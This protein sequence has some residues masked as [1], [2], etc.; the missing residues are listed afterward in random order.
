MNSLEQLTSKSAATQTHEAT[1][2]NLYW[3]GGKVTRSQKEAN[4]GHRAAVVWFTGLSGAGKSTLANDLESILYRRGVRTVVLDGDNIRHGLCSDLGFGATDRH[5]NLRRVGEVCKLFVEA[6]VIVLAAFI[7]P[8]RVDRERVRGMVPHGD[9]IEVHVNCPL[10]VCENRD[11]KGIYR[12]VRSGE[13]LEFTGISSPYEAPI[14][15]ELRI[16]TNKL[17]CQASTQ[18]VLDYLAQRG[19]L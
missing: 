6:G 15:P 1:T 2:A 12:R 8:F 9:F 4:Q 18:N 17:S 11:P 7:S 14:N 3:H 16:D 5:E 19:V 13:I 10:E